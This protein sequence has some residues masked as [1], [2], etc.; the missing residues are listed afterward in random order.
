[1]NEWTQIRPKNIPSKSCTLTVSKSGLFFSSKLIKSFNLEEKK[2]ISFFD[3]DDIYKFGFRFHDSH[4]DPSAYSLINPYGTNNRSVGAN[5]TIN[6]H[7]ILSKIQQDPVKQNRVFEVK[8]EEKNPDILYID[9]RPMFEKHISFSKID[10]ISK[11]TRGIYRYL[12]DNEDVIYIGKGIIKNRA[13]SVERKNWDIKQIQ[14]SELYDE[15]KMLEWEAFYIKQFIKEK[16]Y[17]P[18]YNSLM[19]NKIK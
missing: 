7:R 6:N 14:Y 13:K 8:K 5:G 2:A 11:D 17:K 4:D 19:G 3:N 18:K 9:L 16:G 10:S 1:M 15:D 12:N